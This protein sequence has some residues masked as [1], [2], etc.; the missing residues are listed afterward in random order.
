MVSGHGFPSIEVSGM[1]SLHSELW[2][3]CDF[4]QQ[5]KVKWS[6]QSG[7]VFRGKISKRKPECCVHCE[8][9]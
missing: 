9:Q 2:N 1:V 6:E 4:A 7:N 5:V 8:V 3:L